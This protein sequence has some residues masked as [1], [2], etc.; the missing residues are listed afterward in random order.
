MKA[1]FGKGLT[2]ELYRLGDVTQFVTQ[3]MRMSGGIVAASIALHPLKNLG[4]IVRLNVLSKFLNTPFAVRWLTE[5][6]KAPNTRRGAAAITR[7]SVFIKALAEEHTADPS[8]IAVE[9]P[10]G[11][12]ADKN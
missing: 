2:S 9:R 12:A 6:L 4:R 7:L 5:G 11:V 10:G 8:Q 3:Q 1:T